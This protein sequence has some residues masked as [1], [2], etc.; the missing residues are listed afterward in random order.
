MIH[1]SLF[2][3]VGSRGEKRFAE[4]EES[5]GEGATY[6]TAVTR[7]PCFCACFNERPIGR[8]Q[9]FNDNK[10]HGARVR[11]APQPSRLL[12]RFIGR[13]RSGFPAAAHNCLATRRRDGVSV[14]DVKLLGKLAVSS[15]RRSFIDPPTHQLAVVTTYIF[16][17]A[18]LPRSLYFPRKGPLNFARH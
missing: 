2:P 9:V 11:W 7:P 6:A 13:K 10:Q 17:S 18:W 12:H 14:L 8:R 5:L 16:I 15:G 3:T 1:A 4:K